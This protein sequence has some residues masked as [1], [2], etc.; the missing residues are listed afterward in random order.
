MAVR[1]DGMWLGCL[2]VLVSAAG[3]GVV[4]AGIITDSYGN[5]AWG[6]GTITWGSVPTGIAYKTVNSYSNDGLGLLFS[7]TRSFINT[8]QPNDFPF[9]LIKDVLNNNFDIGERYMEL[10]NYAMG[11]G[12]CFVL[13]LLYVIFMPLCGCCFCC[14]RCCGNCG[15]NLKQVYDENEGCK[16]MGF[17]QALFL[18]AVCLLGSAACVYATNDRFTKAL[19]YADVTIG[20][21]LDDLSAY[22]NNSASEF[23]YIA[24]DMYDIVSN[25]VISDIGDLGPLVYNAISSSLDINTVIDSVIALDTTLNSISTNMAQVISDITAI[26]STA[27]TLE[28]SI[29]NLASDITTTKSSC[30]SDCV[31]TTACDSFSTS[32]LTM[33]ADFS[34]LPDLSSTQSA[35][36]A[37][38][39]QNLTGIASTAS[40]ALDGIATTVNSST[41]TVRDSLQTTM[42]TFK[43][44]LNTM[45]DDLIRNLDSEFATDKIKADM[46]TLFTTAKDY[47]LYR[48]YFGYG[49][50]GVFSLIPLMFIIGILCGCA[51][52]GENVRPTER[53]CIPS[54]GGCLMILGTGL[55][56]LLSGFLMLLTTLSFMIGG[57]LEKICQ[58]LIDLTIFKEF[59]DVG[60]LTSFNL[61]EMLLDNATITI[62][63]YSLLI[64][65]RANKAPFNLLHLDAILPLDSALNY[66]QYLGDIDSQLNDMT[67]NVDLS[68]FKVLTT[69]MQ[70]SL[71]DFKTSGIDSIDFGTMNSTLA[72][73]ITSVDFT[74]L[75]SSMTAIESLCT[76]T[77]QSRWQT[78]ISTATTI[79]DVEIPAV[80]S[81]KTA[82]Q[83]SLSALENS[84]GGVTAQIDHVLATAAEAD[85]QIQNNVTSVLSS[86]AV[87]FKDQMLSYV[88]SYILKV[89]DMVYNDLAK[90]LPLWTLY[91]SMTTM[92]CSYTVDALNGFWFGLGWG[93]LFA[94]PSVVMAVRA[95]KYYR[96]MNEDEGYDDG[97]KPENEDIDYFEVRYNA[98]KKYKNR[99]VTPDYYD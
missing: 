19:D 6:N 44:T 15:G 47:D 46:K 92:L 89:R 69:D 17:A 35:V 38:V 95:S 94:I 27:S 76:G 5:K 49:L 66:S 36:D 65:C 56:F 20:T 37:V 90:C 73:S 54:C 99:K 91:E 51:C 63:M 78:H 59:L 79:R 32:G 33:S 28:S 75:I 57:N 86:A 13:G 26:K 3:V 87:T 40:S 39:A 68:N 93:L 48:I 22:I 70:N 67:N 14:C 1:L 96:K 83:T 4:R 42:N 58:T 16:R 34:T 77:T 62:S 41:V 25:A 50:M 30:S 10:V 21:N 7:F 52:L 55:I 81:A 80:E 29:N 8:V 53:G 31:P 2:L 43:G 64:G 11:F 12:I 24:L 88:D 72:Q 84:I 9:S 71:N 74:S 82:L 60:G 85:N 18:L 23:S 98:M 61:G 45:V 97:V